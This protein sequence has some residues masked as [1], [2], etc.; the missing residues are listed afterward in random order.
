M[1]R[2]PQAAVCAL[3]LVCAG[4]AET[5]IGSDVAGIPRTATQVLLP[6]YLPKGVVTL[7]V[8]WDTS[9]KL[10]EYSSDF[11]AAAV[12]DITA[13]PFTLWHRQMPL[14]TEKAEIKVDP[15]TMLL[16]KVSSTFTPQRT[17]ALQQVT[18]ILKQTAD[19]QA[20]IATPPSVTSSDMKP[21]E[22]PC[23]GVKVRASV[24]IYEHAE[25]EVDTVP[26]QWIDRCRVTVTASVSAVSP[27]PITAKAVASKNG[28]IKDTC[29]DAVCL[30]PPR[31]YRVEMKVNVSAPNYKAL[32]VPK[33]PPFVV[34]APDL[35]TVAYVRFRGGTFASRETTIELTNGMLASYSVNNGS[36]AVG[37]L[38]ISAAALG[39][40]TAVAVLDHR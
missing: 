24:E 9:K 6:Y 31:L 33:I 20:A 10:I 30:R 37:F 17:E 2:L 12:A 32:N 28:R 34:T 15:S 19:L 16:S 39:T 5:V 14:S 22:N 4:C 11:K 25:R 18:A 21:E 8:T 27:V 1:K 26:I 38:T 23:P 35:N 7:D 29:A 36:E 3:A 13:G 40:A